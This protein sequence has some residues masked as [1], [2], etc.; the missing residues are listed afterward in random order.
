MAKV[1]DGTRQ[2]SIRR[3]DGSI[4]PS[5]NAIFD[6]EIAGMSFHQWIDQFTPMH[7]L[8]SSSPTIWPDND[9]SEGGFEK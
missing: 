8:D 2:I 5:E 4:K 3:T 6:A 7:L 1:A 9:Q